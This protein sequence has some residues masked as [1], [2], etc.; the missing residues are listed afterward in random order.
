MAWYILNGIDEDTE[1]ILNP[2]TYLEN[3]L[4]DQ[5]QNKSIIDK[6]N[7][8]VDEMKLDVQI[9]EKYKNIKNRDDKTMSGGRIM[10]QPMRDHISRPINP[11]PKKSSA[12]YI[13]AP[14]MGAFRF[15]IKRK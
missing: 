15:G 2:Y 4:F 9:N 7:E 13:E 10:A 11:P 14:K 3:K 1:E 5:Q 6:K 8:I 12:R